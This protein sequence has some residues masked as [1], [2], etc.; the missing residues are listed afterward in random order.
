MQLE[1]T[2]ICIFLKEEMGEKERRSGGE[3]KKK[4]VRNRRVGKGGDRREKSTLEMLWVN[5]L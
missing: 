2:Y 4:G 3:Q 5:V 1:Y